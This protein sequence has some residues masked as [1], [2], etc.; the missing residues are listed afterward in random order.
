MFSLNKPER[1]LWSTALLSTATLAFSSCNPEYDLTRDIDDKISID[2]DISAPLGNSEL[3]LIEDF[4]DLK[5]DGDNVLKTD[6]SG[7][8]YISVAGNGASSAVSLPMFSFSGDPLSDGGYLATIGKDELPLP[9]SGAVPTGKYVKSFKAS[10][11]PLTVNEKVPEE[12]VDVRDFQASGKVSLSLYVSAGKA[13]LSDLVLDFPDYLIFGSLPASATLNRDGNIVTIKGL[14]VTSAPKTIHLDITGIDM[15]KV[16]SGQGFD[17]N[18]HRITINDAIRLDKFDVTVMLQDLGKTVEAIPSQI[19][20]NIDLT[21][22]A[23]EVKS[24]QVKVNPAISIDPV[25]ANV[26][27]MPDFLAGDGIVLDLSNPALLLDIRNS[28]PLSLNLN[29]DIMSYKG[30][31]VRTVHVGNNTAG[32][33]TV[34]IAASAE[35]KLYISRTGEGAAADMVNV[36]VPELSSVISNVPERI[37][38]GNIDLKAADEFVTLYSGADYSISYDYEVK[39]PLAFGKNVH[40]VYDSDFTGWNDTF[41]QDDFSLEIRNADVK[42]DF[43]NMVPLSMELSASAI[44]PDGNVIP[45]ISV[46]LDGNA[47]AGTSAEPSL[48]SLNLNMKGDASAM[49]KLDGIRI[50]LTA[51]DPDGFEGVCLNREQGVQFKNMRL[52]LQGKADTNIGNI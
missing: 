45:D 8:L 43:V 27:T 13:T 20:T 19:Q 21:I 6:A 7:D 3:I 30:Q 25:T 39:A 37:G 41:N 28:T 15:E 52:H 17:R 2:A 35:N 49:R 4:L 1:F 36:T 5:T 23:L 34:T 18:S 44:D 16:P 50:R 9:S 22:S 42:F 12:I 51:G 11:T 24:A 32:G 14:E 40:I 38:V 10:S 46:T 33:S 47:P 48:T 29:A 26:G 31:N